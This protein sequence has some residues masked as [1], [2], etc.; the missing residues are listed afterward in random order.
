M[1]PLIFS[2]V[3]VLTGMVW[4][5]IE[6]RTPNWL[7]A[8]GFLF[9]ILFRW[10]DWLSTGFSTS[11][12]LIIAATWAALFAL[13]QLRWIGGGDVKFVAILILAFPHLVLIA[14][15]MIADIL[16]LLYFSLRRDG[17]NIPQMRARLS[18]KLDDLPGR[19]DRIRAIT[20]L[21]TGWFAWLVFYLG[22]FRT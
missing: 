22:L 16:A 10:N 21:G 9:A 11:Q 19:Q 18:G 15:L 3:W 8:I 5:A 17:L 20:F 14:C 1:L 4:N 7:H 2:I 6:P 12:F 13:W